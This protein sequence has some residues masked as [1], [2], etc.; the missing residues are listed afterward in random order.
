MSFCA[1]LS[2]LELRHAFPEAEILGLDLS[3]HFLAVGQYLQRQ[4]EESQP[5]EPD[6]MRCIS[7]SEQGPH[8]LLSL[9]ACYR[10]VQTHEVVST[11]PS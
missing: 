8:G 5:S 7:T 1:G 2:T 4:R 6:R 10:I 9:C 11:S 3:P